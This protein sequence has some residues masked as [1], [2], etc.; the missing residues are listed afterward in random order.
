MNIFYFII[1]YPNYLSILDFIL[2]IIY[3]NYLEIMYLFHK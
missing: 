1:I 3:Y 2:L